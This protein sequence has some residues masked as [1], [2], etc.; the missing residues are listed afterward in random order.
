MRNFPQTI[1]S[2]YADSPRLLALLSAIDEWISQDANL[3]N[4]YQFIWNLR[5]EGG[6]FGYGLD[7][8]GRIVNVARTFSLTTFGDSFGFGEAGDRTGFNQA[9]FYLNDQTTTNFTLTDEVYRLL[10]FARAA[11]NITDCS[12]PAINAILMNLFPNRGN[13]YVTDGANVPQGDLFGFGEAQDRVQFGLGPFIDSFSPTMP[14]PMTM[15][16]VFEFT[17]EPFEIAMVTNSGA[18]PKPV[19]VSAAVSYLP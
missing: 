2:Q 16:Y 4:F 7:V 14:R 9:N 15:V 10:I 12:I 13:A 1:I 5:R 18:L 6:A 8:W 17:L 3:E 19:G 11:L